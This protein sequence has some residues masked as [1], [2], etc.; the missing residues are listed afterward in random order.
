M[1]TKNTFIIS[2]GQPEQPYRVLRQS[3]TDIVDAMREFIQSVRSATENMQPGENDGNDTTEED[4]TDYF[5]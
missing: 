5:D 1:Y 2:D 4:T 3:L